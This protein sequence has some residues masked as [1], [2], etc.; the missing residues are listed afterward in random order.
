MTEVT[1]E[2]VAADTWR[3]VADLEVTQDQRRFVA[4]V[5]RYLALCAYGDLGWKANA[6]RRGDEIIGFVMDGTEEHD[7]SYWIGGFIIDRRSQRAGF[8]RAAMAILIERGRRQN[9]D[10]AALSYDPANV[11]ARELYRTLGFVETGEMEGEEI[12]A[13]LDLTS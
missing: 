4:P 9:C 10:S 3:E 6:I 12:V 11:A 1:V 2:A 8:G 7:N 5:I 13:R